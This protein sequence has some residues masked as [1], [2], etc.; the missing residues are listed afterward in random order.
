MARMVL[1][2][3][4]TIALAVYII[5]LSDF[6]LSS[7][8]DIVDILMVACIGPSFSKEITNPSS[9]LGF[10][11]ITRSFN[12]SQI[13]TQRRITEI[14]VSLNHSIN[15]KNMRKTVCQNTTPYFVAMGWFICETH[16]KEDHIMKLKSFPQVSKIMVSITD[17]ST[18]TSGRRLQ[19]FPFPH[20]INANWSYSSANGMKTTNCYMDVQ[21]YKSA[22][23]NLIDQSSG[24]CIAKNCS[25]AVNKDI[26]HDLCYKNTTNYFTMFH[27]DMNTRLAEP[28]PE[29][30]HV[31]WNIHSPD[32]MQST[33]CFTHIKLQKSATEY[34]EQNCIHEIIW[35]ALFPTICIILLII[36]SY[37]WFK[38]DPSCHDVPY[39]K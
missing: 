37:Q 5:C 14:K 22:A 24:P 25:N 35:L 1:M 30:I 8:D 6:F 2:K 20:R 18:G 15:E 4:I 36:I 19:M 10:M 9:M 21:F 31:V 32:K 16:T 34:Q 12:C 11:N 28:L 3:T 17:R 13:G 29:D 33:K 27:Q 7:E 39:L 23:G 38:R 26:V